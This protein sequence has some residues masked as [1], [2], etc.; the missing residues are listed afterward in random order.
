MDDEDDDGCGLCITTDVGPTVLA[1]VWAVAEA[2]HA[3]DATNA[4]LR[5]ER[6]RNVVSSKAVDE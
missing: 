5:C 1:L 6:M 3:K 4:E 2:V